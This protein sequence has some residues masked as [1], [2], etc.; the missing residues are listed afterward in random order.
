M[1]VLGLGLSTLSPSLRPRPPR[2]TRS[3]QSTSFVCNLRKWLELMGVR[4]W[5]IHVTRDDAD[6]RRRRED[7]MP[8]TLTFHECQVPCDD[9]DRRSVVARDLMATKRWALSTSSHRRGS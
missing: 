6:H 4:G 2:V 5:W 3:T 8:P 9:A 1:R 7:R